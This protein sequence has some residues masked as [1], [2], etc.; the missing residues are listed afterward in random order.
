M[1]D[2]IEMT[3]NLGEKTDAST[4]RAKTAV[5][6]KIR[7]GIVGA[8][9]MGRWHAHALEK[10]GGEVVGFADFE[11]AKAESL[12]AEYPMAR[13]FSDAEKMLAG[14]NL[15]VLHVCS[16]TGSH[17]AIAET[18]IEAGVHLLIEKPLAATAEQ[19]SRLYDLA[20]RRS[21]LLC[22]VHQFAFQAGA[23][24]AKKE[25][26]KIGRLVHLEAN[27]CSA[28]GAGF[29]VEQIDSTAVDILPHPLSVMQKFLEIDI[30][31]AGWNVARPASGELRIFG[32]IEETSLSI[33]I[34]LNSR[35]TTNTF[36][37]FGMNGAIHLDFF[38]GF[39]IIE[40]GGASRAKKILHP[41]D[42]AARS[43]SAATV[44]LARRTARRE[45]AYPGL[46]QLI[47]E[48]YQSI[49]QK[50]E[51]P[52]TTSEAVAV[53]EIRDLVMNRVIN[54]KQ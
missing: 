21:S 15:D 44:N 19:T 18:A 47:E 3:A 17:E 29:D 5:N 24:K 38:H 11:Q 1:T 51:P 14:Q 45:S 23:A 28:G 54:R 33:F 35:P 34:S 16:P 31:A 52:I 36:R 39:S 2:R 13:T 8:G 32:Q 10:A 30:T 40:P 27:I 41:F 43:F 6:P 4:T 42:L 48:F 25:L 22:P 49:K 50:S 53:A 9:L 20:A 26:P 46:R 7:A 12:A 37:I